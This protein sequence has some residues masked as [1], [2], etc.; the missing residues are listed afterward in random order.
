MAKQGSRRAI[1]SSRGAASRFAGQVKSTR[2]GILAL[3][4]LWLAAGPAHAVTPLNTYFGPGLPTDNYFPQ[5][6][7]GSADEPGVTVRSRSRPE[8]NSQGIREGAFIIRPDIDEQIGYDSNVVGG[9]MNGQG[10]SELRS[11]GAVSVNSDYSSNNFGLTAGIADSR[12]FDVPR[13]SHTDYN[14]SLGGGLNLGRDVLYG[15]VS[16]LNANEEPYDIGAN[17]SAIIQLNKPLNFSDSDFRV[18]YTTEVGR[19]TL[20]PNVD[21]QMLRFAHGDFIGV[22]PGSE[23]AF[24]QSLRDSNVLQGGLVARYEFQPQRDAVI[25]FNGNYNHYIRG[26][27]QANIGVIDSTGATV[28]AGLDYE[29]TGAMTVRALAGYQQ[30]FFN[31]RLVSNQ[32]APIGEADLIWNPTGLTTVTGRYART[33]EDATT[34]TVTGFTYDRLSLIVDHELY[35]FL[36][37]Q[38]H[39]RLESANY[40]GSSLQQT[41]YGAGAGVTYLIN[42]NLQAALS[43][44]FI[45]HTSSNGIVNPTL[46]QNLNSFGSSQGNS[47]GEHTIFFH[48]RFGL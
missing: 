30:R 5:G 22:P 48:I 26:G 38:G 17:G 33:I 35:R 2:A 44:E 47:F 3:S 9:T 42:R 18:S 7:P 10:S 24:N 13:M 6:V 19:F 28:L 27:N 15:S 20:T 1:R 25:V 34:D 45:E 37:L 36:L 31:S 21:Y 43:Y 46:V 41:N 14:A 11:S 32:G 39:V 12:Y 23:A 29:L 4:G 16:Y 40:Q 8:Y